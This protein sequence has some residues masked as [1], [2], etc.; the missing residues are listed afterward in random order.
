MIINMLLNQ[1]IVVKGRNPLLYTASRHKEVAIRKFE[2]KEKRKI[3]SSYK[4]VNVDI[5]VKDLSNND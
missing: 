2:N 1:W 4:I 3:D 5:S